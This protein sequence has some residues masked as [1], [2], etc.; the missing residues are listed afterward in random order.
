MIFFP[1]F[2]KYSCLVLNSILNSTN[3]IG[4]VKFN[5]IKTKK[6]INYFLTFLIKI[7]RIK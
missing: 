5:I 1:L 3:S 7:V 6:K 2:S 4:K